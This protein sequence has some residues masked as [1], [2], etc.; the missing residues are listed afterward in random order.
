MPALSHDSGLSVTAL[1]GQ[2]DLQMVAGRPTPKV[3]AQPRASAGAGSGVGGISYT[4]LLCAPELQEVPGALKPL[5]G[6]R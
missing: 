3:P 5:S 2:K 1:P 4:T 6:S